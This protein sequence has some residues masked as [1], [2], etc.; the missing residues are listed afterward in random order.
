MKELVLTS[1]AAAAD[2]LLPRICLVCGCRLN[3][4]ERHL[5]LECLT[6]MPLTY[7]W[8]QTRNPMA[9]RFNDLMQQSIGERKERYA[10]AAALFIFRQ[11]APY[12]KITY[13]IKYHGDIAAGRHFGKML[14][15]RLAGCAHFSDVDLIIP[16]PL[17]WSRRL[18][19][20]YNQAEAI[21]E[22]LASAMGVPV[23]TDLLVRKRKTATQTRLSLEEKATNVKGAF[24]VAAEKVQSLMQVGAAM[25]SGT[26]VGTGVGIG[27]GTG[28]GVG[29][30]AG[31]GARAGARAGARDG[32]RGGARGGAPAHVLLV[33]DVFTTGN[34]LYACFRALRSVFPSGVRISVAT[35]GAVGGG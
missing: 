16:V 30:G 13:Q 27:V 20:G 10:Y 35:L 6:E 9:D 5:C 34:T 21:A 3:I 26:G 25:G 32:A 2:F 18:K 4:R 1:I 28:V 14:G 31:I 15:E 29:T 19:R 8:Q 17:H 12:R 23:R 22:G 11:D 24:E 33:D 7:F